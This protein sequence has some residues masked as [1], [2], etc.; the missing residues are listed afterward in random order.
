MPLALIV[1]LLVSLAAAATDVATR[2]IP[3]AL[4]VPLAVVGLGV[5]AAQG[6]HAL[7]ASAG[8]M[9]AVLAVGIVAHASGW[10]GGGDVKLLAAGAG[11]LNYPDGF[12]F[13]LYT[14]LAGGV[15]ALIAGVFAGRLTRVVHSALAMTSSLAAGAAPPH[16]VSG[17]KV[18]Y[19]IAIAAGA[20]LV[21]LSHLAPALRLLR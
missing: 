20:V 14:C 8:I 7:A 9:A 16:P 10:M 17:V 21:P 18:P 12:S 13:V 2:R 11:T 1:V 19:G 4:T 6:W 3:N 15:V 5:N